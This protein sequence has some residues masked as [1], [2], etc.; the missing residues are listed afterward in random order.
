[1]SGGGHA[2]ANNGNSRSSAA[3]A[4]GSGR[5]NRPPP[6]P[7]QPPAVPA[8]RMR[9]APR[10]AARASIQPGPPDGLSPYGQRYRANPDPVSESHRSEEHTS[11][12]QSLMRISYAVFCLTTKNRQHPKTHKEAE[13]LEPH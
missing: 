13:I 3:A 2:T 1:M 4:R 6:L 7:R 5:L 8:C 9:F 12:L 10:A 11:E